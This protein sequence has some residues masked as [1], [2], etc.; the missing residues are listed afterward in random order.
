VA[1]IEGAA[2][3]VSGMAGAG[4]AVA[5]GAAGARQAASISAQRRNG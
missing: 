1:L 2:V 5:G 4:E 3:A